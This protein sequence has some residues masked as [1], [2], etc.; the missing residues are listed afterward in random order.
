MTVPQQP[1][2][3]SKE[4]IESVKNL[5]LITGDA[6]VNKTR[7]RFAVGGTDLG[8]PIMHND[9]LYLFLGDTF[10]GDDMG[11]PMQGGAWRSNVAAKV[12]DLNFQQ[13][14]IIEDMITT[15][16]GRY[17]I[18][19]IS[20]EKIPGTEH[21]VI[22]TGGISVNDALYVYFMSVRSWG[23]PGQWDINYGGLA[24]S[25]DGETFEK[26]DIALDGNSFGQV[27]VIRED[28]TLYGISI[29]GG[30]FGGA[31][32]FR[33][34][35]DSIEDLGSYKYYTGD[36]YA[37]DVRLATEIVKD[38]VGEPSVFFN[39]HLNS[40]VL[41]YLNEHKRAIVM[42]TAKELEGPWSDESMVVH[43]DDYPAL[44]GGFT[45]EVMTSKDG[46]TFYLTLSMWD[47]IYNVLLFEVNLH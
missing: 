14:M 22:P 43:A 32:L 44:Y 42:R 16:N 2:R 38:P 47:P 19:L 39:K 20:S 21:T 6:S 13:G 46:K 26:V 27:A 30:R 7:E 31:H 15:E 28:D 25:V 12:T 10:L 5:G 36:R 37:E 1:T 35:V 24:K 3:W 33:V 9:T 8:I 17:A 34:P 18:E 29:G 11:N 23:E 40:Y 45:H 41:T 4:I